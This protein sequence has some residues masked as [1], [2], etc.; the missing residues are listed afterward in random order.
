MRI[1]GCAADLLGL[2]SGG[3]GGLGAKAVA[4]GQVP[5]DHRIA[6]GMDV[7]MGHPFARVRVV[8]REIPPAG[9]AI[10]SAPA[11]AQPL[12]HR[13]RRID[14]RQVRPSPSRS[15]TGL[16]GSPGT[17]VEPMW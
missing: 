15:I 14:R 4:E 6:A 13:L 12:K 5:G 8:A 16:A 2:I 17:A 1:Q 10:L 7:Q 9:D 3:R 11:P